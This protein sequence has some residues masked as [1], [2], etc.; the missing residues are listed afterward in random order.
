[1]ELSCS[2]EGGAAPLAAPMRQMVLDVARMSVAHAV[3]W[4]LPPVPDPA[5]FPEPLRQRRAVFVTLEREGRLRGCIGSVEPV[6]T[7]VEDVARQAYAAAMRD[8]RFPP[9]TTHEVSRL[10]IH[11]SLLSPRELIS[12]RD[13]AD[14]LRQLRP[15]VDGLMVEQEHHRG[16][17]LPAVWKTLPDGGAF[18]RE[19]RRK[20]GLDQDGW[21]D[22]LRVWRFTVE[23]VEEPA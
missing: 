21:S 7:L 16:T 14:L 15:G 1:M 8:P 13:E 2:S 11:I 4:G 6:G 3:A 23:T 17:F 12:C 9:V 19:L 22:A 20:A 18:W 5:E 10:A